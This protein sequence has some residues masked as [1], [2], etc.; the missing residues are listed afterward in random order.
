MMNGS[1]PTG[2]VFT[3]EVPGIGTFTFRRRTLGD[4]IRIMALYDGMLGGVAQP[5]AL[6]DSLATAVATLRTLAVAWPSEAW[7]PDRLAQMDV[8]ADDRTAALLQV[9][10]ALSARED[11]FRPAAQRRFQAPREDAGPQPGDVVPPAIQPAA[12]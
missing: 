8:L 2:R 6:L 1:P 11:E 3:V 7:Q 9:F 12:D 4:D 5:S 10:G